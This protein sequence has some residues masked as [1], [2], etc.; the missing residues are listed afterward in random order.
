MA[1]ANESDLIA[2]AK[3]EIAYLKT[4]ARTTIA[5]AWFSLFDLAGQPGAGSLN[6]GNTANGLV[7]T[8]AT[9]GFPAINDWNV[10]GG[11]QGYISLVEF[12]S[13]VA[14][15]LALVDRLFH[16]GSISATALATTTLTSQPSFAGRLTAS[17][18]YRGLRMYLEVQAA[19][20][21]TATTVAV[22]YTNDANV[23]G[24]TTGALSINGLT[25]G[26]LLPLPLQA[27]DSGVR[28]IESVTVGG[29]V[30]S[31]GA[32]NVVLVRPLWTGRVPSANGGD[33]HG[34]DRTGLVEVFPASA[35]QLLVAA[36]STGSGVPE[37]QIQV[38]S[39]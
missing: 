22:T 27:G 16:V 32:F 3:R 38:A 5:G 35:L 15:R 4:G 2:S 34:W 36:D 20:S 10:A 18:S 29:T 30:A 11:E 12:A 1:I 25:L 8:D 23:A 9:L 19:I 28:L 26:R 37:L 39:R 24:R 13:T 21:A 7:P 6:V 31:A 17:D 33:V 14:G